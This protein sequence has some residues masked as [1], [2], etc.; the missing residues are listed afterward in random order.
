MLALMVTVALACNTA[1]AAC[2]DNDCQTLGMTLLSLSSRTHRRHQPTSASEQEPVL[3][4]SEALFELR[5]QPMQTPSGESLWA[6]NK[7][8]N[9]LQ[10]AMDDEKE[11]DPKLEIERKTQQSRREAG[12]ESFHQ[13][14]R[15]EAQTRHRLS[16]ANITTRGLQ[17]QATNRSRA[18]K[19]APRPPPAAEVPEL[20]QGPSS[21]RRSWLPSLL[22]PLNLQGFASRWHL[23]GLNS[24][25][26]SHIDEQVRVVVKAA[27]RTNSWLLIALA[28]AILLSILF[29]WR[30]LFSSQ[31]SFPEVDNFEN[32]DY[33]H[34]AWVLQPPPNS[35]KPSTG[36]VLHP[37]SFPREK[38][39]SS[40]PMPSRNPDLREPPSRLF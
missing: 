8:L 18:H 15:T 27:R 12:P 24:G 33:L 22:P 30:C 37:A 13:N 28:V 21:S 10:D 20:E 1:R 40:S 17:V 6:T 23:L 11:S 25:T 31:S 35:G 2:T 36:M 3:Q 34:E 32:D 39:R 26:V 38:V 19:T 7:S 9:E 16:F 29:L 4:D 14:V 5:N